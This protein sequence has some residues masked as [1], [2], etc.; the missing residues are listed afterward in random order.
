MLVKLSPFVTMFL[1]LASHM[2]E[3]YINTKSL[4]GE[5]GEVEGSK[6]E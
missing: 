3:M 1:K 4:R 6:V 2:F 5:G